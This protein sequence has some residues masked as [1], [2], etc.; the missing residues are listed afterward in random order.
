MRTPPPQAT[1]EVDNCLNGG[2]RPFRDLFRTNRTHRGAVSD[3][4]LA[5]LTGGLYDAATGACAPDPEAGACYK[6]ELFKQES[7]RILRGHDPLGERPLFL[8]HAFGALHTPLQVPAAQLAEL[9]A[10]VARAGGTF[11]TRNQRLY[12][13][14]GMHMDGVVRDLVSEMKRLG[15]WRDTLLVFSS[16]NGGPIYQPG[17]ANNYPLRGGKYSDFEGGVRTNAFVAGGWLP[18]RVRGTAHAGLVS[19]ADWYATL[20]ALAGVPARDTAAERANAWLRA[21]GLPELPA[22]DGVDQLDA[23]LRGKEGRPRGLVLSTSAALGRVDGSLFKLVTGVQPYAR[24]SSATSPNCSAYCA[25]SPDFLEDGPDFVDLKCVDHPLPS[26][27]DPAEAARARWEEDC[28]EQGCLYDLD[29]DPTEHRDLLRARGGAGRA[30]ERA[31]ARLLRELRAAR[32]TA[33]EPERG[34]LSYAACAAAVANGGVYGPFASVPEFGMNVS[35]WYTQPRRPEP[36][37]AQARRF[38]LVLAAARAIERDGARVLTAVLRRLVPL[39]LQ[40]CAKASP[41][42]R[43]DECLA[44]PDCNDGICIGPAQLAARLEASRPGAGLSAIGDDSAGHTPAGALGD[45]SLT[46]LRS[47]VGEAMAEHHAAAAAASAGG[48]G[49]AG[50]APR[51]DSSAVSPQ[52]GGEAWWAERDDD[53]AAAYLAATLLQDDTSE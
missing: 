10:L 12:A 39:L 44:R 1:G 15:M 18:E 14:M 51:R 9:D 11:E 7:L 20:P 50:L 24:H 27:A 43:L 45:C 37:A 32:A 23:L 41:L 25:P 3:A 48:G 52:A 26:R 31:H 33:F 35:A 38:G 28:A 40:L 21:R 42:S 47:L 53:A 5:E 34:A 6:E 16:D 29:A 30:A 49:H 19:I 13:A 17:G 46:L 22:V 8:L 4:E 2:P 36:S